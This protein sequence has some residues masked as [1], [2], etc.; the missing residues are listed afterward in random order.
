MNIE[1]KKS[2]IHGKGIF[3]KQNIKKG[4]IILE[5]H[6]KEIRKKD[7]NKSYEDYILN[8]DGKMFLMQSPE[9][10]M[11]HSYI[12]NS[13]M[14]LKN[15]KDIATRDIK[16]GEEIT[17]NYPKDDLDKNIKCNCGNLN[18]KGKIK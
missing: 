16:K 14:D 8:K 11:N 10:Y 3:A 13:K 17:S 15:L 2:K 9:K 1:I 4:E 12:P 6:P 5:W 7:I 18:C